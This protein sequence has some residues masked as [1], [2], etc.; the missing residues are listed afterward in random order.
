MDYSLLACPRDVNLPNEYT[1]NPEI[2]HK[3]NPEIT[4]E[5]QSYTLTSWNSTCKLAVE[6]LAPK[7]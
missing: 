4:P 3:I 6:S 2:N 5:G 1:I 7:H